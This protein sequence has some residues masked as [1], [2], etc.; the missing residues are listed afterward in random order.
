MNTKK[1]KNSRAIMQRSKYMTTSPKLNGIKRNLS[2]IVKKIPKKIYSTKRKTRIMP[3]II[4]LKSLTNA[5]Q[6][7]CWCA[8]LE[9]FFPSLWFLHTCLRMHKFT[10]L[11]T[12]FL[13]KELSFFSITISPYFFWFFMIIIVITFVVFSSQS[14]NM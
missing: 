7:C 13:T 4:V 9:L 3:F 12:L 6:C 8:P 11:L 2:V 10:R 14:N 1:N 5:M